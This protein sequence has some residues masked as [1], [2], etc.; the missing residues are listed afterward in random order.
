MSDIKVIYVN[1]D[2]LDQEH[3]ESLDSIKM[4]SFKTANYELTDTK[5]GHLV[6][7]NDAA[8]E[9]IHDAR[10]FREN[11]FISVS[12]GAGDAA[13]PIITDAGGKLD[14]SFI[15]QSDI[16]HGSISG[17]GDDDHTQYILVSGTRD[18]SGVVK[19]ASHPSFTLDTQLVDKKYVDDVLTTSE[20][21]PYSALHFVTDNTVAP[22][23][24]VSGDVYVLSTAGGVPHA[25]YDGA[26]AGDI[27]QFNGTVWVATTPTTGTRIGVDDEASVSFYLF[28]GSTWSPK[29]E[30]SSTA[31]TGLVKVGFDIRLDASAAGSGLGF[32]T[33]VLNVNV[34]GASLEINSDIVRVKA[35]GINDT[36]IDWGTG[37]NQVSAADMPIADAG[38]YFLTDFVESA[39]QQ[40]GASVAHPGVTYTAGLG[41]VTKGDLIYVSANNTVLPFSTITANE[42]S[43]GLA[44]ATLSAAADVIALNDGQVLLGVLTGA[45]AGDPYYW[46]GTGY[47][48]TMP[49]SSGSNVW[50]VGIAKNATDLHVQ[51]E[52]IKKNA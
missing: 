7:G 50:R 5:L 37:A 24:E 25:D 34:D 51:V 15:D 17:L 42:H 4:L 41:G 8:D 23:T 29:Y 31:S 16:D 6:D 32:T 35:D 2:G 10:Y 44:N 26:S 39:L 43:V 21:F 33:G 1:S 28:G 20:W 40:L 18:F 38:N 11:E 3:S 27:V 36:H 14:G 47:S 9:H 46:D 22:A 30:E 12:A 52:H 49:S 13:K 45:T 48:A 19:Y